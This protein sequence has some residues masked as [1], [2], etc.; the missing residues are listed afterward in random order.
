MSILL[1]GAIVLLLL[2]LVQKIN[3]MDALLQTQ[4]QQPVSAQRFNDTDALFTQIES[5]LFLRDRLEMR[6]GLPYT[7]DWSASPDFLK[8]IVEHCLDEKPTHIL[9]CSSGLSSLLLARCCQL[10]QHGRVDSLENGEEYAIKSRGHIARYGLSA[11]A[12]I[13]HAPLE[14]IE[15]D[16]E[17]YLWYALTAIPD[18][19]IDM[20]VIDGPPGYLQKQSRY[21]AVPL[22]FA[23][24]ADT[25]MVFLDDAAR[26]DEQAIVQRWQV[27]YPTIEA[28][29]I[30][31][32]RGCVAFSIR[33]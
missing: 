16:G 33:K 13:I 22:L 7:R 14:D 5:Y 10:N 12:N 11:Y 15:L 3:K 25:C 8:I 21:P 18:D 26:A 31:A 23:K 6:A 30:K 2:Y 20:L 19:S 27:D 28:R 29:T 32:Q 17:H 24:L 4:Q 9:E 1:L